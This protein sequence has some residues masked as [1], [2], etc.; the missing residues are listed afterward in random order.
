[1]ARR[2]NRPAQQ[3]KKRGALPLYESGEE[4]RVR[5]WVQLIRTFFL[6]QKKVSALLANHGLTIAQFDVLATLHWSQGITQQELAEKLLVTKGNVCGLIDRLEDIGWVERRADPSDA[7]ARR[8]HLTATGRQTI[9]AVF[10]EHDAEVVSLTKALSDGDNATLRGLLWQL[11][12]GID[13][14]EA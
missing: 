11:E 1:M 3:G 8:L 6:M 9:E 13:E 14:N 10:P 4:L 2:E 7:R 12:R 5:M